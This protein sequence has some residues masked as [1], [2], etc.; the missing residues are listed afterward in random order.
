MQKI[1]AL[2]LYAGSGAVIGIALVFIDFWPLAF[3]GIV[4]FLAAISLTETLRMAV[5]GGLLSWL[6]K[7][8]FVTSYILSVYPINFK[9]FELGNLEIPIILFYWFTSALVIALAGMFVGAFTFLLKRF[10]TKAL[11]LGFPLAWLGAEVLGTFLYAFLMKGVG[12]FIQLNNSGG[13]IGYTLSQHEGM[14]QLAKFGGVYTLS[15]MVL[16]LGVIV[17]WLRR[18]LSLLNWL[19]V[20]SLIL[21]CLA[22]TKSFSF[23]EDNDSTNKISVAIIDTEFGGSE[24]YKI[25]NQEVYRKEKLMSAIRAALELETDYLVMSEDSRYLD[26][27][28][29]ANVTY[30]MFRFQNGDPKTIVIDAGRVFLS[31]GEAALRAFIY[32]GAQKRGWEIDKQVLV[33]MGEYMPYLYLNTLRLIGLKSDMERMQKLYN[34]RPGPLSDQSKLPAHLPGILFCFE[35]LDAHGANRLVKE[36]EM[37]FIAHPISHAWF[38]ESHVLWNQLDAILKVQA[39]WSGTNIVSA[40]NMVSGALYTPSGKKV[41][42][43]RVKSGERWEV[44]LVTF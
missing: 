37:P 18:K 3:L 1:K 10:N 9:G 5:L 22:S 4:L 17:W 28:L 11:L 34:Y 41:I 15:L 33:P 2:S 32:D 20:V 8:L 42:P 7:M 26:P 14:V 12:S 44:S 23:V 16:I 25:E 39:V 29:S 24:Y 36:R 40:G 35:S 19:I 6:V 27:N 30:G 31:P 13:Y 43:E 38:H 21:V